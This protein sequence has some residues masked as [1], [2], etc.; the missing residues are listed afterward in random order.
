MKSIL[1]F[2]LF[3][4]AIPS[5]VFSRIDAGTST[6]STSSAN[7]QTGADEQAL[8]RLDREL[9]E[10][11]VRKDRTL[12]ERTALDRYVFVNPVGGLQ[13]RGS[14]DGPDIESAQLEN[15]VVRIHGDT[16]VLTGRAMV[17]GKFPNGPDIS[18]PYT[19]MRVFVK[20][21]GQWRLAAG[22]VVGVQQPQPRPTSSP[23]PT[24]RATP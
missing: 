5:L 2:A 21:N 1:I 4:A 11:M 8:L 15:V 23:Q 18:G 7:Q 14:P 13:E 10:A 22:S 24:P 20:Q 9:M 6:G 3:A 17:K 16:A 19:Y 12:F